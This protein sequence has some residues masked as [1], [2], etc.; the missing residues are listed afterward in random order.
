MIVYA[1]LV[2]LFIM[3]VLCLVRS[4]DFDTYYN[5][6]MG[7]HAVYEK[8]EPIS[9]KD[10]MLKEKYEWSAK[11]KQ[12]E[13]VYDKYYNEEVLQKNDEYDPTRVDL[14]GFGDSYDTRFQNG[15]PGGEG[16]DL[17]DMKDN[18]LFGH[19]AHPGMTGKDQVFTMQLS[20]KDMGY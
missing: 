2:V 19:F 11:D 16:Y 10:S 9:V 8:G 1:L 17:R 5:H 12:G 13:N 14:T 15:A 18:L 4:E 3:I 6:T 20:E 7:A